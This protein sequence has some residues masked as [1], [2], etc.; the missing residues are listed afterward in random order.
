MKIRSSNIDR[1]FSL[2]NKAIADRYGVAYLTSEWVWITWRDVRV[3]EA[4]L[5]SIP[6]PPE[7]KPTLEIVFGPVS[8]RPLP[9]LPE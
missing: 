8:E 1:F 3:Y 4:R 5:Y 7:P 2:V 9:D 6:V